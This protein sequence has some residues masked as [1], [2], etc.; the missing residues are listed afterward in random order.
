MSSETQPISTFDRS[1]QHWS[2]DGRLGMEAFYR[3]AAKDYRELAESVKWADVIAQLR[4]QFDD[5]L[6]VLDVAC[7]SGQFPAAL[8]QY[9]GWGP[10]DAATRE[11]TIPYSLLD[12]SQFSIDTARQKLQ[13]PF[14]AADE[15]QCTAQELEL[16]SNPFP[17]VWATHA[18][19]CVPSAEL[20]LAVEK[21]VAATDTAGLGFIA[22]A[23]E[24]AHY[25][26]FHQEY[27][28]SKH[29][30]GSVPY[31]TAEEVM[32]ALQ[33]KIGAD[34]FFCHPIEYDGTVSLDDKET[35]E[36][37]LQRCLFDDELT[38]DQMMDDKHL[39][40]YLQS[41]IDEPNHVWRFHQ[42]TWMIFYGEQASQ[43]SGWICDSPD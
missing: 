40:P 26:K 21:M 28:Q 19:Y 31:C 4:A 27:L 24:S 18:L 9:G 32:A 5:Q 35:A 42:R 39:Q 37:Y 8:Q 1:C 23:S 30:S 34:Q 38:L 17:I 29:S 14:V 33:S 36:R 16:T 6:R 3:L 20:D 22:H 25:L 7:G 10:Q 15:L 43:A 11:L 2:E 41:C 12:P 13:P